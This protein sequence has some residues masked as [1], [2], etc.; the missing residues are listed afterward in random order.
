MPP[1]VTAKVT[2]LPAS[3]VRLVGDA[4]MNGGTNTVSVAPELTAKPSALST[5]RV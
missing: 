5:R 4:M 3:T 1:A 2:L